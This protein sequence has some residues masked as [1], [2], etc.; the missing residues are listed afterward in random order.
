MD[1]QPVRRGEGTVMQI[2][3]R[4]GEMC[5]RDRNHGELNG[6]LAVPGASDDGDNLFCAQ[7]LDCLL[8]TSRCV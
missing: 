1:R 4:T 8:Y 3:L 5:I 7:Y 2:G 6:W